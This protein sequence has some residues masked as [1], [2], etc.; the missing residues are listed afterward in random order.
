MRISWTPF[1]S[2]ACVMRPHLSMRGRRLP[3]QAPRR[4]RGR[5]RPRRPRRRA[6]RHRAPPRGTLASTKR[7]CTFFRRPARRSPGGAYARRGPARRSRG[8]RGRSA[9]SP[10]A[11]ARR[12]RGRRGCRRRGPADFVPAVEARSSTSVRSSARGSR[13]AP[14]ASARRFRSAPGCR[15][16]RSGRISSRTRPRFVPAFDESTRNASPWSRQYASVSSRQTVS[17]GRTTPS[18]R[19]GLMPFVLPDDTRR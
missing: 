11:A 15:R 13:G 9:R 12:T 7:S 6:A 2:S 19:R 14:S 1:S 16:R 5:R 8:A 10:R 3:S 17:S 4:P 18:S